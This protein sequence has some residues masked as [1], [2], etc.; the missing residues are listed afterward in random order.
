VQWTERRAA[1]SGAPEDV[2]RAARAV[3]VQRFR[4]DEIARMLGVDLGAVE[5][6][7]ELTA[8]QEHRLAEAQAADAAEQF[9]AAGLAVRVETVKSSPVV[10]IEDAP[11]SLVALARRAAR[12]FTG[13][14]AAPPIVWPSWSGG[15]GSA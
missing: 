11:G 4:N 9:A 3:V 12:L 13:L 14:G 5:A 10:V 1:A 6:G 15:H 2:L 8:E 7:Q